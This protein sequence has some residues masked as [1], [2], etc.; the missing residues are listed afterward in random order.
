MLLNHT[1]W[2][3]LAYPTLKLNCSY[4]PPCRSLAVVSA[5]TA[6]R[7]APRLCWTVRHTIV[8]AT[9]S[10]SW[11]N[12]FPTPI[13]CRQGRVGWRSRTAEGSRRAASEMISR[14][15]VTA[16]TV[17]R[18]ASKLSAVFPSRI[19]GPTA[20]CRVCRTVPVTS[21]Q[22]AYTASRSALGR[23]TGLRLSRFATSTGNGNKSARYCVMPTY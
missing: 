10:W 7:N 6:A 9:W 12:T 2:L 19:G 14:Q 16:Y 18:S 11:R 13:I 1:G 3:G 8:S 4:Q 5:S 15:R 17:R 20:H 23:T 21:G 22:E